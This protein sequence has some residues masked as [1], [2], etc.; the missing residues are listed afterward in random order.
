MTLYTQEFGPANAP[1]IVFL[2]GGGV[3]GWMWKPQIAQLK[4]EYHLLVP[5]LPEHGQSAEVKPL[6]LRNGAAHVAELIRTRAHDGRAH[7]V[8]LSLGA[9]TVIEL[10]SQSPELIDHAIA[11]GPLMRPLPGIGLTNL[12]AKMYWPFRNATWLVKWNM[13]GLGV[14]EEYFEDFRR[15]TAALTIDGF[16]RMTRANGNN[17]MPVNLQTVTVPTLLLVG[18]KELK[19]MR[20][21]VRDL[22][23]AMPSA[24]GYLVTGAIHN[25]SLQLPDLFTQAV[26]AWITGRALPSN[27]VSATP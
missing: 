27:L 19:I 16:V 7:V 14:P 26:R 10:L 22:L 4:D 5:D 9:Q 24:K 3:G 1:T 23:A 11:S 6:T 21:S 2:H 8:G 18:E 17:H 15:D 13:K 20:E 12:M 25:W